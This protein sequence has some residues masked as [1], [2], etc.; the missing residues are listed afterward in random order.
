MTIFLFISA[1]C[2]L[3]VLGCTS[4]SK[5]QAVTPNVVVVPPVVYTL[6]WTYD[7]NGMPGTFWLQES[8]DLVHWNNVMLL[9]GHTTLYSITNNKPA[10][11]FRFQPE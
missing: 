1:F 6:A 4:M 2:F 10:E 11:Y 3:L 5:R 8:I 9:D 7:T